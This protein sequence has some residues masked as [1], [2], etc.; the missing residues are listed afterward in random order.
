M[1]G[2]SLWQLVITP[3]QSPQPLLLLR[4]LKQCIQHPQFLL[5]AFQRPRIAPPF[6]PPLLPPSLPLFPLRTRALLISQPSTRH[7]PSQ[8]PA[9]WLPRQVSP[10]LTTTIPKDMLLKA[11]C[12]IFSTSTVIPPLTS[13]SCFQYRR[14]LLQHLSNALPRV[15]KQIASS[16]MSSA[17][18]SF[19]T[20]VPRVVACAF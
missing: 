18:A 5:S 1:P 10:A 9:A 3:Q 11:P 16:M 14:L 8:P 19:S 7:P 17:K 12:S 13:Q 2:R 20:R 15:Q 6:L 4:P